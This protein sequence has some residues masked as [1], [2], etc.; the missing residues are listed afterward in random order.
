L[1]RFTG[2]RARR[3]V[4]KRGHGLGAWGYKRRKSKRRP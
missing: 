3:S 4:P 1:I 2:L